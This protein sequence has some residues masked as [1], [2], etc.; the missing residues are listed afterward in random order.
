MRAARER[1]S[2]V[3]SQRVIRL[4]F[5]YVIPFWLSIG[6][7]SLCQGIVVCMPRAWSPEPIAR[8]RNGLWALVPAL[9][10]I[11]F[12]G[13]GSVAEQGSAQALTYLAL[14]AVPPLAALALGW[15]MHGAQPVL[16]LLAVPLFGLAWADRGGLAG[17]GAALA[18]SALSCV[19]LGTLIASVTPARW[20]ALGIVVMAVADAGLVIADLLQQPN[21]VLT[22]THPAGGLPRLQAEVLSS[23]AMG[24]GDLFVAGVLGGLLAAMGS[25]ARQ[26]RG[27]LL[28]ASLAIA[29]DFLFFAV[30]ELPATVPVACG[31]VILAW[32]SR[33]DVRWAG[34][35]PPQKA[36][37]REA[38][39][40]R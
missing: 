33:H 18:L 4:Y 29:F 14:I 6:L 32:A 23:A 13:V 1:S 7:L 15:L 22:A 39:A 19:T 26:L 27:G 30:S 21:S 12:V 34:A 31:L 28:V 37:A 2:H 5:D 16:A 25:R 24:Y 17:Q 8:V 40:P 38:A 9:S 3:Q 10:V 35:P 36:P 11:A 20:L